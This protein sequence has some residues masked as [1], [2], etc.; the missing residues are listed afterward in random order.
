MKVKEALGVDIGGS[1]MKAAIVDCKNGRLI[2]ERF[3][4]ETPQPATPE[5]MAEVFKQLVKAFKWK[6][7]IGCGFP[8]IIDHGIAH[9]AANVDDSWFE[10]DVEKLFTKAV[11][12][13][14]RVINDADAAG[15]AEAKFGAG[16]NKKGVVLLLT[17]GTGIGSALFLN[18]ELVPN[19][20][21]GHIFFKGGI[22]EHYT[23]NSARKKLEL[24][25]KEWGGRLN[26]FLDHLE[27]TF[28]PDLIILGGGVS[29]PERFDLYKGELKI[30]TKI[31]PAQFY[32]NAGILGAAM[33]AFLD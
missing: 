23:A 18:G 16:K 24:S 6:G 14:V 4:I 26:E 17:I 28:S 21:L 7:P 1:G 15:I 19:T 33:A 5:A 32:N 9:S 8:A 10:I 12:Q 22:A 27:R 30:R 3:R 20:E 31:V 29:K 25:W 11:K 13:K 2:T